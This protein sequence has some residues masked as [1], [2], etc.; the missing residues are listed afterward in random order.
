[1]QSTSE[2]IG[3]DVVETESR[4][5]WTHFLRGLVTRGYR[6]AGPGPT[7]LQEARMLLRKQKAIRNGAPV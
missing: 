5:S 6:D 2:F 7:S 1:M 4:E 3:V